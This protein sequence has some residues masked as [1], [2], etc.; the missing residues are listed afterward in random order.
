M[1]GLAAVP[2]LRLVLEDNQLL[3]LALLNHLAED[4][5]AFDE[6]VTQLRRA[7]IAGEHQHPPE[8]DLVP[9]RAVEPLDLDDVSRLDLVLLPACLE[10]RV[11]DG[12]PCIRY[13]PV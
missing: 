13:I 1:P 2:H 8:L 3:A 4:F 11:H 6:R 12:H 7:I 10:D 9:N 5:G